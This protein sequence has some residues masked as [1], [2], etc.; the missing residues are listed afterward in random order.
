MANADSFNWRPLQEP[1][2]R[3]EESSIERQST[4]DSRSDV[5]DTDSEQR[6][7]R[8]VFGNVNRQEWQS[9]ETERK[10]L[11]PKN[12][13]A[14][15]SYAKQSSSDVANAQSQ[16]LENVG[17]CG[18]LEREQHWR[19]LP[20]KGSSGN[21]RSV[22]LPEPPVGR[23]VNGLPGRVDRL[24]GLGNA[25]VPQIAMQIGLS[26]KEAMNDDYTKKN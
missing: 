16:G 24:R 20:K 25:I 17:R 21:G 4:S 12:R 11:Q 5:A 26:I 13:E 7:N 3:Q 14:H 2:G 23:V 19:H 1:Q 10:S 6:W 8:G 15:A 9:T 18:E 22:W